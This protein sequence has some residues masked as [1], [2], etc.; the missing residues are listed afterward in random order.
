MEL[1]HQ[2]LW[3]SLVAQLVTTLLGLIALT[4]ELRY[5]DQILSQILGLEVVVQFIEII[6]YVWLAFFFK[7]NML[8]NDVAKY[9]YYDWVFTTPMMLL[10]TAIFFIYQSG[11]EKGMPLYSLGDFFRGHGMAY[12]RM[13]LANLGMLLF[14]YL[15]EIR[16]MSLLWSNTIGFAFFGWSFYELYRFASTSS[17]NMPIFWLMFGL[18]A[19]YGVSATYK[20]TTKNTMYNV[21]DVF[22]KNFYGVY[23]SW[24]IWNQPSV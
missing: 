9:R 2:T 5:E 3:G 24:F 11:K 20:N 7:R 13:I 1:V 14:G 21:L 18:W 10:S 4:K 17:Q 15:H 8:R 16:A 19:L 23:L 22:S 12:G 6:F